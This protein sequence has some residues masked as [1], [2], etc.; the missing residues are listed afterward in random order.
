MPQQLA[1]HSTNVCVQRPP[2]QHPPRHSKFNN[3]HLLEWQWYQQSL[4]ETLAAA[5]C[6]PAPLSDKSDHLCR[7]HCLWRK[8]IC[9]S[10]SFQDGGKALKNLVVRPSIP[11]LS[12]THLTGCKYMFVGSWQE[13]KG[14][15]WI[16]AQPLMKIRWCW[17][18]VICSSDGKT[19]PSCFHHPQILQGNH[20]LLDTFPPH[21]LPLFAK[22]NCLGLPYSLFLAAYSFHHHF[23]SPLGCGL[24]PAW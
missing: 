11:S 23:P 16:F 20:T 8:R 10:F 3:V 14:T 1:L 22:T 15:P 4:K 7:F 19:Q 24:S 6:Q 9:S 2:P 5:R 12:E 18:D 13:T 21:P 17:K